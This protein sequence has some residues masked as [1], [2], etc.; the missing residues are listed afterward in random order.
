MAATPARRSSISW[1]Q[2]SCPPGRTVIG[3]VD[4]AA[5]D[6]Y[7]LD[8]DAAGSSAALP[9]RQRALETSCPTA[10]IPVAATLEELVAIEL[11]CAGRRGARRPQACGSAF[12]RGVR[13]RFPALKESVRLTASRPTRRGSGSE[14]DGLHRLRRSRRPLRA[15]RAA[16]S[17]LVRLR[18]AR[19]RSGAVARRRHQDPARR[20]R[21]GRD[22]DG[23]RRPRGP[24]RRRARH[25]SIVPVHRV[26]QLDGRPCIVSELVEDRRSRPSPRAT[27][28]PDEAARLSSSSR[29]P[30]PTRSSGASC[31][32]TQ[33]RQRLI[34]P[35]G[36]PVLQTSASLARR[37]GRDAHS[38][39]E[40]RPPAGTRAGPR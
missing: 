1:S 34:D 21:G 11:S 37:G 19:A 27:A 18:V 22:G 4:L 2:F 39:G 9:R 7:E 24:E 12:A 35:G 15:R 10:P 23:A 5:G 20:H 16:G 8:E 40:I 25:P 13:R 26:V 38:Q 6:G 28:D 33:A 31:T 14:L 32:A 29:G 36:L 3:R 30:S 17:W